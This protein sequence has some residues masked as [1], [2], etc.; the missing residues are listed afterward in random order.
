[1]IL[2]IDANM[3]TATVNEIGAKVARLNP[4]IDPVLAVGGLL[5]LVKLGDLHGMIGNVQI[6][7]L[8]AVVDT[9]VAAVY[10]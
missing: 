8:I 3:S 9:P 7:I 2:A 4:G 1:M 6:A 10:L 5:A